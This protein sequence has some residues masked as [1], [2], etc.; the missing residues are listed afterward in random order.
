HPGKAAMNGVLAAL[1]AEKGF[2]GA[3]EIFEGR[4]GFFA[5]M[6]KSSE[7]AKMT[8]GLGEACKIMENSFKIHASCRH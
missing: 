4:R 3:E 6:S 8:D 1:L 7:A 2:T 5:A